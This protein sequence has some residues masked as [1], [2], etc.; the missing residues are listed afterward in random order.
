MMALR[1]ITVMHPMCYRYTKNIGKPRRVMRK[2]GYLRNRNPMMKMTPLQ[3]RAD[4]IYRKIDEYRIKYP[5]FYELQKQP[6]YIYEY[7]YKTT[8]HKK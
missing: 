1:Y 8:R 5:T 3:R 6:N 4:R 7:D 2:P